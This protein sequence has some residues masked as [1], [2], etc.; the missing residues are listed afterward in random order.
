MET[1]PSYGVSTEKQHDY[2][3]VSDDHHLLHHNTATNINS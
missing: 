2:D 1:N 3:Y